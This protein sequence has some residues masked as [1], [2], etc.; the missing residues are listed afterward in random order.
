M[1]GKIRVH[2]LIFANPCIHKT[3]LSDAEKGLLG[4]STYIFRRHVK[5]EYLHVLICDGEISPGGFVRSLLCSTDHGGMFSHSWAIPAANM[6]QFPHVVTHRCRCRLLI[7]DRVYGRRQRLQDH[8]VK[9]ISLNFLQVLY[10]F[11]EERTHKWYSA[12]L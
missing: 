4:G 9:V 10:C 11:I 12:T 7:R 3:T 5:R 6:A 1:Q 2:L 8:R